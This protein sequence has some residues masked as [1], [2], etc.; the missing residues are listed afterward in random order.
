MNK[1]LLNKA[2]KDESIFII[3]NSN[4]TFSQPYYYVINGRIKFLKLKKIKLNEFSLEGSYPEELLN[5][6]IVCLSIEYINLHQNEKSIDIFENNCKLVDLDGYE[7]KVYS[8]KWYNF[9]CNEDEIYKIF[10]LPK[11]IFRETELIPKIKN[12]IDLFF[13]VPDEDTDY[14]FLINSGS[15][16]E[17]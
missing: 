9:T 10:D 14:Y 15:I 8:T 3:D 5:N 17:L 2:I 7:Y 4:K 11:I 12:R 1:V 13:L 16:E 6:P